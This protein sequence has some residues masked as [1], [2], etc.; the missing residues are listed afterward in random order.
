MPINR[1]NRKNTA[2]MSFKSFS[3]LIAIILF[4]YSS[5]AISGYRTFLDPRSMA[6][7]GTGVA[8]STKFNASYHNPALIAFNRGEKPDKIYISTSLGIR[9]IYNYDLEGD[10][11]EYLDQDFVTK[12]DDLAGNRAAIDELE[13]TARAYD[14]YMSSINLNSYRSDETAAFNL[15]V[16]TRPVTMNFYAR[17]D[18]RKITT[19]VYEDQGLALDKVQEL[20]ETGGTRKFEDELISGVNDTLFELSEFGVTVATTDVITYNMPISWGYTAKLFEMRGS[21]IR[22]SFEEYD[23]TSPPTPEISR[24]LLEWNFD[25]GFSMLLTDHFIQDQFGLD[26]WWLEG[27]W[28]VGFVGMNLLPT[29]FTPLFRSR[30]T[31]KYPGTKR[32]IQALYQLGIAH[33]REDY[34]FTIDLDIE[35]REIYSFEGF[36]RYLSVGGEYFWRK[37]FHLRGGLRLNT[38]DIHGAGQDRHLFTGGFIYNP[39]QFSIEGGFVL[40]DTEVGGSVGLGLAF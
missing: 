32:S 21:H 22:T 11:Q 2:S 40:N 27:E 17:Q 12:M 9:E 16:D 13:S 36:T 39:G 35:E 38:A 34:M 19:I 24:G 8:A 26:G 37:D 5:A 14:S 28:I 3:Y 30:D 29:D 18:T 10:I 6:M 15:L 33:Y 20:R 23:L 4:A 25:I 31:F 7:G 1:L